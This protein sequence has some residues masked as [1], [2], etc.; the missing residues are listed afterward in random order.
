MGNKSVR[1]LLVD[2]DEDDY[3]I[4]RDYLLENDRNAYQLTW[5]SHY[6][7]ALVAMQSQSFDVCLVDYR[8]G[9][10]TGLELLRAATQHGFTAP[11]I[12]LT[13]QG[14]RDTDY[15]AMQAGAADYLV[16]SQLTAAVLERSIRYAMKDAQTLVAL[17]ASEERYALAARG[18]N[19]GLW[20]W[21][22]TKNESYYSSRWKS[23]LGYA[24]N[25]IGNSPEE[26]FS[27]VHPDDYQ[28]LERELA[29]HLEGQTPHFQHEHRMLHSQG[30]YR[31]MLSRG[32]AIRDSNGTAYRMAGSQ[33]DITE[34]REAEEKL[35]HDAS[36]DAL[37][38][39]PNRQSFMERL[40]RSLERAKMGD[41][42]IFAVL[43]LDL[44]RFKIINDSLGH[45]VGDL[46]LVEIARRLELALRPSDM[47]ARLGGDEFVIL[48]DHLHAE[49]D[50]AFVAERIQKVLAAPLRIGERDV[51]TTASIGITLSSGHSESA[52][53][54]LRDADTAMYRAKSNGKARYEIFDPV[55]RENA[56]RIMQLETDLRRALTNGEF[57]L[58]YQPIISLEQGKLAGFESLIRWQ[59]PGKG[60]VNPVEFIPV[61]EDN[62]LINPI[63]NWVLEESCRQMRVWQAA[64]PKLHPITIS[65]N[66]S[67]KQ[68]SQADL[69]ETI[70]AILANAGLAA[71]Y[72]KLEITES[73][74]M[75][76]ADSAAEMLT[77]LKALGSQIAIDDFGTGYSSFSHLHRFPI[78]T[79]KID[80]AFVSRM[81]SSHDSS[82]IVHAILMLAHNLKME[83]VAEG[84]ETTAQL[85]QLRLLGC[86]YAQGFFLGKPMSAAEALA[87][88]SEEIAP[89]EAQQQF[90][91][92]GAAC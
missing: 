90:V 40:R 27:R 83:V 19:D 55:M 81:D 57:V 92:G 6:D 4:T 15:E 44:D 84:V 78:D 8:L 28:E 38:G 35:L 66:L 87:Y 76:N 85:K 23:M 86:D 9:A 51:F 52:E 77:E 48:L 17:R 32:I 29:A 10:H 13:G 5:L 79:L 3:L 31:W 91:Q 73:V 21:D 12:L 43:F 69:I 74:L 53:A 62:G 88:I 26:W 58:Y 65:V 71:S 39:L 30:D 42:Y 33:T 34:R 45:Q 11:F 2:D 46:L 37:T 59:R 67:A 47:L 18:A 63:G 60:F 56:I 70:A 41:D 61:A 80:R 25:S 64:F 68:F 89:P 75:D 54:I 82:E 14:D 36:H 16:K 50:A 24:E 49:N 1:V 22:L 7:K 72:L 20:D